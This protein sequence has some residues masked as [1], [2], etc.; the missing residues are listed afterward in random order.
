[1]RFS[2]VL[3]ALLAAFVGSDSRQA[4]AGLASLN[5]DA[6]SV[7]RLLDPGQTTA[8]AASGSFSCDMIW[9]PDKIGVDRSFQT[10]IVVTIVT[11]DTLRIQIRTIDSKGSI[12][13]QLRILNLSQTPSTKA[14]YQTYDS[15]T[16]STISF[17]SAN[18]QSFV[19]E[20][21]IEATAVPKHTPYQISETDE[22][23][24]NPKDD[25][26]LAYLL[27]LKKG[28]AAPL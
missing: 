25:R 16:A 24:F 4:H 9:G 13:E 21:S 14:A 3:P 28:A 7:R 22:S 15:K 18:D 17:V 27:C 26:S 10:Q 1:M 23:I 20:W 2:W 12:E 5:A 19:V 6:A 11:K 8:W